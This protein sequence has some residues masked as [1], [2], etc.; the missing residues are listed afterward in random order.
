MFGRGSSSTS[1]RETTCE[2]A[3]SC[4]PAT[5]P[6]GP[7]TP[8]EDGPDNTGD[9]TQGVMRLWQKT[10]NIERTN[11]QFHVLYILTV[12]N[13]QLT[14]IHCLPKALLMTFQCT[15]FFVSRLRLVDGLKILTNKFRVI[16][17]IAFILAY[18]RLRRGLAL[19]RYAPVS[20]GTSRRGGIF[21][22]HE[23]T[24][25]VDNICDEQDI[26]RCQTYIVSLIWRDAELQIG[27]KYVK[28]R[29]FK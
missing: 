13:I 23:E 26:C 16:E 20:D 12:I 22:D 8:P 15:L 27:R 3:G 29:S 21:V 1:P 5:A 25:S 18:G 28:I 19:R 14:T 10:R 7:G 17:I 11:G 6:E 9:K 4:A 24:S 2:A